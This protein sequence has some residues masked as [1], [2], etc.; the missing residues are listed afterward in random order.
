MQLHMH[1]PNSLVKWT[2]HLCDCLALTDYHFVFF[3]RKAY[4]C[5]WN[6]I[7]VMIYL[8]RFVIFSLSWEKK[9]SAKEQRYILQT[10]NIFGH[11][12]HFSSD[13]LE[14]SKCLCTFRNMSSL[15]IHIL[16][17]IFSVCM[18]YVIL[19]SVCFCVVIEDT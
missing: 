5:Q 18:F 10:M 11:N 3:Y 8:L 17:L 9:A 6:I 19:Y 13:K 1:I 16:Q 14:C 12:D 7:T 15:T 2:L 4:H